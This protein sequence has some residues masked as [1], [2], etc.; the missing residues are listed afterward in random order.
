MFI[1]YDLKSGSETDCTS[2]EKGSQNPLNTSSGDKKAIE[3]FN[4][5]LKHIQK[6]NDLMNGMNGVK[7]KELTTLEDI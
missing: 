5:I 7:D 3:M 2:D 1:I 6:T 4:E